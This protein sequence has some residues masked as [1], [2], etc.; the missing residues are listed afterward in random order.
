MNGAATMNDTFVLRIELGNAAMQDFQDLGLALIT[1]G[2]KLCADE[3]YEAAES[4][5]LAR[6]INGNTVGSWELQ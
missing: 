3:H 2:E 1:L 5:G 6:D 4:H